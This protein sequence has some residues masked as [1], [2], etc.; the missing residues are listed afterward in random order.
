MKLTAIEAHVQSLICHNDRKN[1]GVG[2][3]GWSDPAIWWA[4]PEK[5]KRGS[6]GEKGRDNYDYNQYSLPPF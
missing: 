3:T 2:G 5:M 4:M 1:R 6:S